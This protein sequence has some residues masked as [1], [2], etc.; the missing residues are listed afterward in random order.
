M[1]EEEEEEADA[2][3]AV[4]GMTICLTIVSHADRSASESPSLLARTD[5]ASAA[6]PRSAAAT[7]ARGDEVNVAA[8]A[9]MTNARASVTA[10][11]WANVDAARE[12]VVGTAPLRP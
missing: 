1:E 9:E 2:G 8:R 7:A 6:A 3:T 5:L 4:A 12:W 11:E 10:Y